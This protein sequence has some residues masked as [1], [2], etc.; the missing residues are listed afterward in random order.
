M[1]VIP[2]I[3]TL[4]AMVTPTPSTAVLSTP[5]TVAAME[6][7]GH[8]HECTE[9]GV[10][11]GHDFHEAA[12]LEKDGVDHSCFGDIECSSGVHP[13]CGTGGDLA[14]LAPEVLE[15]R[16]IL[17]SLQEVAAGSLHSANALLREYPARTHLNRER[18]QLQVSAPCSA[19]LVIAQ[20]SLT[21]TQ[22]LALEQ[23]QLWK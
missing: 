20:V 11:Q 23:S 15:T 16:N 3:I 18:G 8:C 7:C 22:V 10:G 5:F 6:P 19:E 4:T 2:A 13:D 14:S 1:M 21:K 17:A 9:P 12:P